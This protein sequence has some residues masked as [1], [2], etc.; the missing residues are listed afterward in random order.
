MYP[1]KF[2][3]SLWR[4]DEIQFAVQSG[5]I[6]LD[7]PY[8][9]CNDY[10][11][12]TVKESLKFWE[13]G[14]FPTLFFKVMSTGKWLEQHP[15]CNC[16]FQPLDVVT[17]V[18]VRYAMACKEKIVDAKLLSALEENRLLDGQIDVYSVPLSVFEKD[19]MFYRLAVNYHRTA[20]NDFE[21]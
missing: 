20:L 4:F 9:G 12:Q 18:F 1:T 8:C 13:I 14:M 2:E 16:P 6:Y 17:D 15:G 3:H 10:G 19:E 21:M 11:L 7:P 5:R